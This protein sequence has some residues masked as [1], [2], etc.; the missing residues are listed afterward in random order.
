MWHEIINF[1]EGIV[2][3][4]SHWSHDITN[5]YEVEDDSQGDGKI[6]E[7]WDKPTVIITMQNQ[8]SD[9]PPKRLRLASGIET[10][11]RLRTHAVNR[12][13]TNI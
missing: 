11:Y 1:D 12:S 7:K 2:V 13:Q 9:P 6:N 8:A 10:I 3:N 5:R 4:P